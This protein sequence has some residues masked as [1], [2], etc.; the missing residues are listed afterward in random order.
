[1]R[2]FVTRLAGRGDLRERL[3]VRLLHHHFRTKYRLLWQLSA[4]VPHFYDFRGGVFALAFDSSPPSSH[5]LDRAAD[6]RDVMAAG[7]LVLDIGCGDGFFT[8]RF[9]CERAGRIDAIDVEQSAIDHARCFH[10]DPKINYVAM[11]AVAR[12]FPSPKY[13]VVVWNGAL[14]HFSQADTA[15][16]LG[17]VRAALPEAGIFVG[18]ESLGVE[19]HD[20]LQ[21]LSD[22]T[23][24]QALFRPYFQ[25]VATRV[26]AYTIGVQQ[27][28][29]RRE[30]FWRC[31]DDR[32]SL[33]R[34]SWHWAD[35]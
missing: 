14:G 27:S 19:G 20:H 18:S 3:L 31:S 15:V 29:L 7:D 33:T 25:H 35:E 2:D 9:Y 13:D 16:V 5:T 34:D 8:R 1:M 30:I 11:D 23:A 21:Y 6:A 17:K 12:A 28:F 24:V 4:E 26:V 22:E 10:S 32:K